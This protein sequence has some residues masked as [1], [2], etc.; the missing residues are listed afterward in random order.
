MATSHQVG[1]FG[2]LW[3]SKKKQNE[4]AASDSTFRN[5]EKLD[6]EHVS[7]TSLDPA[8]ASQP[9]RRR[10]EAP[11]LVR[12]LGPEVRAHLEVVLVKKIDLRLLPMLIL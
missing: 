1:R 8:D 3:K 9:A 12:D 6:I 7:N 10:R 2:S 11:P 5:D 4:A